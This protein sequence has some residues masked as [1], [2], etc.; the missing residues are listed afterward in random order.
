M[1]FS[2]SLLFVVILACLTFFPSQN[3]FAAKRLVLI[4]ESTQ[5][6][7]PPCGNFAPI[8]EDFTKQNVGKCITVHYHGDGPGLDNDPMHL[9]DVS[10]TGHRFPYYAGGTPPLYYA[11]SGGEPAT[12]FDGM[13]GT[14]KISGYYTNLAYNYQV[15]NQYLTTR[16]AVTTPLSLNVVETTSGNTVT[17]TVT[18]TSTAAI[19]GNYRM[20]CDIVQ[21]LVDDQGVGTNS[22]TSYSD[23]V[24]HMLP[25]QD[26]VAFSCSANTPK[27]FTFTYDISGIWDPTRTYAVAFVQNDATKEVVNAGTDASTGPTVTTRGSQVLIGAANTINKFTA[28]AHNTTTSPMDI[29][30]SL[31]PGSLPSSWSASFTVGGA[32]ATSPQ[33]VTIPAGDSTVVVVSVD[34]TGGKGIGVPVVTIVPTSKG[35]SSAGESLKFF[36][37]SNDLQTLV[38]D[39]D[40]GN[41]RQS[42][43]EKALQTLGKVSGTLTSDVSATVLAA[44]DAITTIIYVAGGTQPPAA[45]ITQLKAFLNRGGKLFIAGE[46]LGSMATQGNDAGL[47]DFLSSYL[48]ATFVNESGGN[49]GFTGVKDVTDIGTSLSSARTANAVDAPFYFPDVFHADSKSTMFGKLSGSSDSGCAIAVSTPTYKAVYLSYGLELMDANTTGKIMPRIWNWLN[50]SV[51][52]SVGVTAPTTSTKWVQGAVHDITWNSAGLT[53]VTISFS[54]DGTSWSVLYPDYDATQGKY[55]WYI[56]NMQ[57]SKTCYVKIEG[58]NHTPVSTAGPFEITSTSGVSDA[59]VPT[60][61]QLLQNFPNPFAGSTQFNFTIA[62]AS[63]VSLDIFDTRGDLVAT[64]VND[65]RG[66]GSYGISFDASPLPAGAYE[67]RM[68]TPAGTILRSMTILKK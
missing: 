57:G 4:E 5:W 1:R 6:N 33:T 61:V 47:K 41:S 15:L 65:D 28:V 50:A 14:L 40:G 19:S 68:T 42:H 44:D 38:I 49:Q 34:M 60:D 7:C 31:D 29:D 24:L 39:A 66:A 62:K 32:D 21:S 43:Y 8:L 18:A 55:S 3:S 27:V 48:H 20:R 23:A 67:Y 9:L 51:V 13:E 46:I 17:V 10:T 58:P 64:V 2:F 25:D 56:P 36:S 59:S 16:L 30:V 35:A 11:N 12:I 53:T 54:S 45:D 52:A 26:G 63:H 37:V 22:E